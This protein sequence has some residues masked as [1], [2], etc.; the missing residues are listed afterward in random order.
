MV[1]NDARDLGRRVAEWR[2]GRISQREFAEQ[3]K[4]SRT[5]IALLEQGVRL[6]NPDLL[7]QIRKA[8][9]FPR[10]R[11]A[12]FI[13]P[14]PVVVDVH[15]LTYYL[16]WAQ[17]K[18]DDELRRRWQLIINVKNVEPYVASDRAQHVAAD[19]A[20]KKALR[21]P[22]RSLLAEAVFVPVP[23]SRR[24][25]DHSYDQWGTFKFAEALA[26]SAGGRVELWLDR[27]MELRKSSDPNRKHPRPTIGEHRATIAYS[28]PE[29]S[30]SRL[31]LVDDLVTKGSTLTACASLLVDA[32]W[33]GRVNAI[34]VGYAVRP[35]DGGADKHLLTLRWNGRSAA[36]EQL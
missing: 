30:P 14:K 1:I 6:P 26:A 5:T 25:D 3:L 2:D 23:R 29:S 16:P 27:V 11:W 12:P 15:C 24:T 36:P 4:V 32:G 28:G 34:A 10:L 20:A 21:W 18:H 35:R 8:C 9:G 17:A 19:F 33:R 13:G 31:V 22:G 7:E